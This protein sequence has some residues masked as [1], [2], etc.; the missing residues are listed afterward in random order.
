MIAFLAGRNPVS[1]KNDPV[2]A[3]ERAN[4]QK[5]MAKV[6]GTSK[7]RFEEPWGLVCLFWAAGSQGASARLVTP[8]IT[9]TL[10]AGSQGLGASR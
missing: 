9:L 6:V 7:A 5:K 8:A 1:L 3:T 4:L 2:F 10:S